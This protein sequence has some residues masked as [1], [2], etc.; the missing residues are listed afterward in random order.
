MSNISDSDYVSFLFRL[1]GNWPGDCGKT[2]KTRQ[3][4]ISC[5]IFVKG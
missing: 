3:V 4:Q 1:A 5:R 2:G